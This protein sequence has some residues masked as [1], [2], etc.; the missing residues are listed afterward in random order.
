[1][2]HHSDILT[3]AEIQRFYCWN[4]WCIDSTG[5]SSGLFRFSPEFFRFIIFSIAH[6]FS[7]IRFYFFCRIVTSI[8]ATKVTKKI[9]IITPSTF[10]AKS[11]ERFCET[12]RSPM[13]RLWFTNVL[14][15]FHTAA[16]V[17][18]VSSRSVLF[19]STYFN[20]SSLK[21]NN[22]WLLPKTH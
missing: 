20:H 1:V 21:F 12:C 5:G 22:K 17:P 15:P 10:L 11:F 18:V 2:T 3:N 13:L 9:S 7:R 6:F 19:S 16:A 4:F 8:L 14:N